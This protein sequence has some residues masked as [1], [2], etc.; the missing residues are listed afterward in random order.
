MTFLKKL[1]CP[2]YFTYNRGGYYKTSSYWNNNTYPDTFIDVYSVSECMK[3]KKIIHR[4]IL[5]KKFF[6][7]NDNRKYRE[8]LKDIGY[9]PYDEY[10]LK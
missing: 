2:H 3:C 9:A 4:K 7:W 5:T 6:G 1:F 10:I 8:W